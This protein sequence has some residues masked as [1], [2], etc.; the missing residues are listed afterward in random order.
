MGMLYA[1]FLN[2]TMPL[3]DLRLKFQGLKNQFWMTINYPKRMKNMLLN[4]AR[5]ITGESVPLR[6]PTPPPRQPAKPPPAQPPP[7]QPAKPPPKRR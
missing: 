2:A 4:D 7:R 6:R 3:R 1:W 5:R